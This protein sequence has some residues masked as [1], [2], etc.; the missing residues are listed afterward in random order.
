MFTLRSQPIFNPMQTTLFKS[1]HNGACMDNG[2]YDLN[3]IAALSNL[4]KL[5]NNEQIVKDDSTLL[6]KNNINN[7]GTTANIDTSSNNQSTMKVSTGGSTSTILPS[8]NSK[9]N[10]NNE[11]ID[12]LQAISYYQQLEQLEQLKQLQQEIP[13]GLF[14]TNISSNSPLTANN[15][16]LAKAFQLACGYNNSAATSATIQSLLLQASPIKSSSSLQSASIIQ[17]SLTATNRA[18]KRQKTK[19]DAIQLTYSTFDNNSVQMQ[20]LDLSI[21]SASS[22]NSAEAFILEPLN[23]SR[24]NSP[25]SVQDIKSATLANIDD[26]SKQQQQFVH[27]QNILCK[28]KKIMQRAAEYLL[29]KSSC[30]SAPCSPSSIATSSSPSDQPFD[31]DTSQSNQSN[32]EICLPINETIILT[33]NKK[34]KLSESSFSHLDSNQTI[35]TTTNLP[36]LQAKRRVNNVNKQQQ[37]VVENNQT[38]TITTTNEPSTIIIDAKNTFTCSICGEMFAFNDRLSKH[39]K[40]K[41]RNKDQSTTNSNSNGGKSNGNS[42]SQQTNSN[43]RN[44]PNSRLYECKICN[45]SFSRSDMLTRHSRVHSGIKPFNCDQC[46]SLFTRS[47][48]LATHR[49]THSGEKPYKCSKCSYTAC[50]RDMI[51]R[52][53]K[54]HKNKSS[55]SN[56]ST[57][58]VV[59]LIP[60][61]NQSTTTSPIHQETTT[62]DS[63]KSPDDQTTINN[64][65]NLNND[66]LSIKDGSQS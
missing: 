9:K 62:V 50:R 64:S 19:P 33:N 22:T 14:T 59:L 26:K 21:K 6:I 18:T 53:M 13:T 49:R 39:I 17:P 7:I 41:H 43:G 28:K 56:S 35:T 29:K 36:K 25:E 40:S 8:T 57:N 10:I 44:S 37:I 52:H 34:R 12:K 24:S 42:T 16:N 11:I 27:M 3:S 23:L 58:S 66:I 63:Q 2:S 30:S 61:T 5:T 51:T 65:T 45:R 32:L 60:T 38:T 48:H 4:F 55:S 31:L 46:H 20:P 1:A 47:D 54:T 15:L